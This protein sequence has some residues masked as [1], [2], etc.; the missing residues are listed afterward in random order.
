MMP[1]IN[2]ENHGNLAFFEDR[3]ATCQIPTA[4]V[5]N[6]LRGDEILNLLVQKS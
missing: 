2:R 6:R 3:R 5:V 4:R 1:G